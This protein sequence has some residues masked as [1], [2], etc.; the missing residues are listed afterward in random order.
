LTQGGF[1]RHFGSKDALV[2]ESLSN[3]FD[4]LRN[5]IQRSMQSRK[6][7]AALTAAIDDYL[8]IA[9]RDSVACCPFVSLGSELAREG[10][11]ARAAAT[12]AFKRLVEIFAQNF[13]ALSPAKAMKEAT[14]IVCAMIGAMTVARMIPDKDLSASV[15]AQVRRSL[16]EQVRH[17]GVS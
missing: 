2:T 9:H 12:V 6:R 5:S 16:S 15:L 17:V 1:Y 4:A 7:G 10:S 11:K 13:V 14:G 8:S 3:S